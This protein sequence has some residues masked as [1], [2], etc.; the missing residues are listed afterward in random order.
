MQECRPKFNQCNFLQLISHVTN[1]VS[2]YKK[3]CEGVKCQQLSDMYENVISTNLYQLQSY[4]K[5]V[6]FC[7]LVFE[8]E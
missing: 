1:F 2:K 7:S 6:K 8:V 5:I 4:I 3:R